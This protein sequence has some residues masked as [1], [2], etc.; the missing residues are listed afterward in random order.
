[1]QASARARGL[2]QVPR[3]VVQV[4]VQAVEELQRACARVADGLDEAV[5][6]EIVE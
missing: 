1:M 3:Q 4:Q 5:A 2:G 6:L